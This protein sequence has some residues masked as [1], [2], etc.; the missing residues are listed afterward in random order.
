MAKNRG[1]MMGKLAHLDIAYKEQQEIR[2]RKEV[3]KRL[4]NSHKI[5]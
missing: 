1:K 4:K 2:Y 3:S 5:S